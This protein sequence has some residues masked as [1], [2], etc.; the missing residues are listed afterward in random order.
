MAALSESIR[1]ITTFLLAVF[2]WLYALFIL[3]VQ[4]T[5]AARCAQY[6]RLTI[7]ETVLLALLVIFSFA[8]GSGFW[9]TARDDTGQWVW[10]ATTQ[11]RVTHSLEMASATRHTALDTICRQT[12]LM[13]STIRGLRSTL[14]RVPVLRCCHIYASLYPWSKGS[15]PSTIV[16][17]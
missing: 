3:N 5:C 15:I 14:K 11:R 13:K 7:S 17:A 16:P 1:K 8:S 9:A 12:A 10:R 2:I 4:S 6:L